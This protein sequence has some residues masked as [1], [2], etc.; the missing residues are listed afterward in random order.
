M[1]YFFSATMKFLH[2]ENHICCLTY[3]EP[4]VWYKNKLTIGKFSTLAHETTVIIWMLE[5]VG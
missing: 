5:H 2:S 1:S 4:K 3:Y